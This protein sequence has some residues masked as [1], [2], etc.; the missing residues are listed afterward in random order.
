MKKTVIITGATGNLG[1]AAVNRFIQ[2]GYSV[3]ATVS[4]GKSLGY[5]I[6]GDLE[7]AEVDLTDETNVKLFVQRVTETHSQID[8]ALLLVGGYAGGNIDKTDGTLLKKMY[9]LNFE[10]AYFVARPVFQQMMT[11]PEGG[12]LVFVGSKPGLNPEDGKNNLAYGLSKSLI[13]K[14]AEYLNAEGA[15]KNVVSQ[16]IVPSTI[17]TPANRAAMPNAKFSDWITPEEIAGA[18]LFLT[19][20]EGSVLRETVLK[21]YGNS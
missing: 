19:G 11:Q 8:A 3:V 18:M 17:D 1:K 5:S 21:I 12:R 7:T 2:E 13:F 4:P 10:T 6:N 15:G 14:L 16:V 9:S 20:K